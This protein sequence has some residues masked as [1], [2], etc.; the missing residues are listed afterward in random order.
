MCIRRDIIYVNQQ[1]N[2]PG[3]ENGTLETPNNISHG[4]KYSN[5]DRIW[6]NVHSSHIQFSTLETHKIYLEWQV[7]V[8]LSGIVEPLFLY[9][10]WKFQICIPFSVVFVNL[11]MSKIG[12]VNYAHFPKSGYNYWTFTIT[13][14]VQLFRK[15]SSQISNFSLTL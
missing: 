1:Q 12:C 10:S 13:F 9:H 15:E 4:V 14:C 3:F 11:Q 7:D 6:E 8:K 2:W 5:C